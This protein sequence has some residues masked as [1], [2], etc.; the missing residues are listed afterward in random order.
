MPPTQR[1][2]LQVAYS[3]AFEARVR[4]TATVTESATRP[5]PQQPASRQDVALVGTQA[6]GEMSD[7][8]C[9]QRGVNVH[10]FAAIDGRDRPRSLRLCRY[11][12]PPPLSQQRPSQL[13]DGRCNT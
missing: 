4:S 12:A 5:V 8:L 13:S 3:N 9:L 7:Y 11:I 2:Q 6:C 1:P 10:A